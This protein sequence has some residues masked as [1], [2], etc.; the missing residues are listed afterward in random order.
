MKL[1][2]WNLNRV[3]PFSFIENYMSQGL[4][5]SADSI[6]VTPLENLSSDLS[7]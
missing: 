2:G 3:T 7:L 5:L 6:S 1:I 4:V